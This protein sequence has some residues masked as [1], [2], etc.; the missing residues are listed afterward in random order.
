[1]NRGARDGHPRLPADAPNAA[2]DCATPYL[3]Q[4][5]ASQL[6]LAQH[7]RD[8]AQHLLTAGRAEQA[9]G[10]ARWRCQ[11]RGQAWHSPDWNETRIRAFLEA[12]GRS[13]ESPGTC[14]GSPSLQPVDHTPFARS[15]QT[16]RSL[17]RMEAEERAF[18]V[19]G[20]RHPMP[21][22]PAVPGELARPT[23]AAPLRIHALE[24]WDGGSLRHLRT[25]AER[26]SAGHPLAPR[27][28]VAG[29]L[30]AFRPC[31]WAGAKR[32]AYAAEHLR[33]CE[34]AGL[35]NRR[36]AGAWRITSRFRQPP[37]SRPSG[38]SGSFWQMFASVNGIR[39]PGQAKQSFWA[40]W[41]S[42]G[43]GFSRPF[44]GDFP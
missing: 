23:R 22:W 29:P 30:V 20:R 5:D 1:M 16:A 40:L 25:G 7:R 2:V 19:R 11:G 41:P 28:A 42:D 8:V 13:D 33:S 9:L 38:R 14:A 21:C 27:F 3:G 6:K 4:F 37:A 18:Q 26:L 39:V 15:P 35:R 32:T 43:Y 44:Q 34:P 10:G 12:L 24:E 36:L 17:R 31:R